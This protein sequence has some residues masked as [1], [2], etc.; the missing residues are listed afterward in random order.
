MNPYPDSK[1]VWSEITSGN[2]KTDH[3]FG[4]NGAYVP[5]YNT[6]KVMAGLRDAWL[7]LGHPQARDVL[8]RMADWMN[9]AFEKLTDE[10][11]QLVLETE[12]GGVMESAADVYAITGGRKI[13]ETCK[14]TQS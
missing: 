3:L 1:A 13:L 12:H 8:V 14:T 9:A 5:L 7:L 4:L 10:Q 2:I 6:H 11:V